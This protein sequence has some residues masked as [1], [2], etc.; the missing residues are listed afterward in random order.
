MCVC[1]QIPFGDEFLGDY[2]GI[3]DRATQEKG[4]V[5]RAQRRYVPNTA[6]RM[7]NDRKFSYASLA[8]VYLGTEQCD[9]PV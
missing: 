5:V 9:S 7:V 2:K 1:T 8:A 6:G 4:Q 3:V